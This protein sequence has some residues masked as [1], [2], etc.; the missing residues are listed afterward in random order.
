MSQ[1]NQREYYQKN[2]ERIIERVKN[3]YNRK[4]DEILSQ[5]KIY[6]QEN[7]DNILIQKKEY[8]LKTKEKRCIYREKYYNKNKDK[9]LERAKEYK[10]KPEVAERIKKQ[11]KQRNEQNR[12]FLLSRYSDNNGLSCKCCGENIVEFLSIDHIGGVKEEEKH[13]NGNRKALFYYL[14]EKGFPDGYQVLC[15]NCNLSKGFYGEC[16]HQK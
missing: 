16:P 7:R 6:Y 5:K 10:S 14:K 12:M 1:H 4:R 15:Y 3:R 8:G 2:R 13:P 9:I 11:E